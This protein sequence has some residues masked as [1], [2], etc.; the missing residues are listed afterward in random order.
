MRCKHSQTFVISC[1]IVVGTGWLQANVR[2]ILGIV[3]H[4]LAGHFHMR[5][6]RKYL[7]LG[8]AVASDVIEQLDSTADLTK[9]VLSNRS[10]IND[11]NYMQRHS[12]KS[13]DLFEEIGDMTAVVVQVFVGS[14]VSHFHSLAS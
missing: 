10:N 3:A 13:T 4:L 12:R 11:T 7:V 6:E 9:P 1:I 5:R 14:R 8:N 2:H